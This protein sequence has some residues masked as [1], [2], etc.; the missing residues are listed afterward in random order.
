MFN[1]IKWKS[2]ILDNNG[3]VLGVIFLETYKKKQEEFIITLLFGWLG[4]HRFMKN[5][6][7]LGFIYLITVGV[8]GICWIIDT[9]KVGVELHNLKRESSINNKSNLS[10]NSEEKE[11]K[12]YLLYKSLSTDIINMSSE[13]ERMFENGI[14]NEINYLKL[15]DIIKNY[16]DKAEDISIK[17]KSVYNQEY[18]EVLEKMIRGF[19]NIVNNLFVFFHNASMNQLLGYDYEQSKDG[20]QQHLKRITEMKEKDKDSDINLY[21]ILYNDTQSVINNFDIIHYNYNH[22][23]SIEKDFNFENAV[24]SILN[25]YDIYSKLPYGVETRYN[26]PD[27]TWDSINNC[28]IKFKSDED[29]ENIVKTIVSNIEPQDIKITM[30]DTDYMI[31][32]QYNGLPH[33]LFPVL[34][35]PNQTITLLQKMIDEIEKRYHMFLNTVTKGIDDFNIYVQKYNEVHPKNMLEKMPNILMIITDISSLANDNQFRELMT[36]LMLK[37][38]KA[39]IKVIMMTKINVYRINFGTSTDFFE[40]YQTPDINKVFSIINNKEKN[41]IA[42]DESMTGIEFETF[43]KKLLEANGFDNVE[44]T[45]A[46]HDYG[47]DVIAYKDN[48]KYAIQCKKYSSKVGIKA[49]QEVIGSRSMHKCHVGVVLTNNYFTKSAIELAEKNNI[50][51]WDRNKLDELLKKYQEKDVELL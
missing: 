13:I 32:Q 4:V 31:L 27:I 3:N 24:D 37:S 50:F 35:V 9:I 36:R 43:S 29:M 39:G 28:I 18:S 44:V 21:N 45:T 11:D 41:I 46:S 8:F 30:V 1:A 6:I 40:K 10:N 38:E 12:N 17:S 34:S 5:D 23:I 2:I 25:Y 19:H 42:F 51:L 14:L 7:L 22:S 49:V 48:I 15:F 33:L 26:N 16:K 47:V 20:V